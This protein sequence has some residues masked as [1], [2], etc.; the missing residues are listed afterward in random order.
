MNANPHSETGSIA[1]PGNCTVLLESRYAR[2]YASAVGGFVPTVH[3]RGYAFA[4]GRYLE[5]QRLVDFVQTQVSALP[6]PEAVRRAKDLIPELNGAWA[7]VI[8]WAD[9]RLLAATDRLRSIPLFYA[10]LADEFIIASSTECILGRHPALSIDETCAAEFLLAGY[11]TGA[12]TLFKGVSQ[13]R[14]AEIIECNW[15]NGMLA[16]SSTRYYR[17]LPQQQFEASEAR[18]EERLESVLDSV[19]SRLVSALNGRPVIVPLSGGI[20]SR[21]VAALLKRHGCEEALCFTYGRQGNEESAISRQVASVLG[22]RWRFIEYDGNIW[23]Q[24]VNS[25]AMDRYWEFSSNASSLPHFSS[26]PAQERLLSSTPAAHRAVFIPGHTGDFLS[27]GHIPR[28]LA[29]AAQTSNGRPTVEQAILDHHYKLW[30]VANS[31]QFSLLPRAD[32]ERRIARMSALN[33]W[34]T[35]EPNCTARYEMWEAENRQALFIVN[36]VRA[37]E[38]MGAD[39]MIPLWDYELMDFFASVPTA[40]R[41]QQRLYLNT[42]QERIFVGEAKH[43]ARIARAGLGRWDRRA[44]ESRADYRL[45]RALMVQAKRALSAGGLLG[46]VQQI[47]MA[48]PRNHFLAFDTWFANGRDPSS[49]TVGD[50]LETH[51]VPEVLPSALCHLLEPHFGTRLDRASYNGLLSAIVLSRFY[52]SVARNPAS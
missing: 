40:Y 11:V 37:F 17:F 44:R 41:L 39:W 15:A 46:L 19:F 32:L 26:L 42:L 25:R 24:A 31:Q 3:G 27:G 12:Q 28:E 35:P 21:L 48:P 34:N 47:R 30:P 18:L 49:M 45:H 33:C 9:S 38:Y 14:S 4:G 5:G 1:S 51:H 6:L 20:D 2:W 7:L 16:L 50:V 29:N 36:S 13:V 22:Y 43:L 8:R 52:A 23:A 10:Q